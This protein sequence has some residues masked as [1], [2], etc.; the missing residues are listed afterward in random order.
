MVIT[1]IGRKVLTLCEEHADKNEYTED[2]IQCWVRI[3]G[4]PRADLSVVIDVDRKKGVYSIS[5]D[6]CDKAGIFDEYVEMITRAKAIQTGLV[7]AGF[8]GIR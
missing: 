3:H 6:A 4:V 8:S 2:S 7:Q 5:S 1:Q